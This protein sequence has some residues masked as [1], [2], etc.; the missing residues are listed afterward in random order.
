MKN[1]LKF[2]M[3]L[4][5]VKDLI[6]H[7]NHMKVFM[8]ILVITLPSLLNAAE[9]CNEDFSVK[10]EYAST[11]SEVWQVYNDFFSV[12]KANDK[13]AA[14]DYF[15]GK[16][17]SRSFLVDQLTRID[18]FKRYGQTSL[19]SIGELEYF[20]GAYRATIVDYEYNQ[21]T[22]Q[23]PEVLY[24]ESLDCKLSM[25]LEFENQDSNLLG[26]V[27]NAFKSNDGKLCS[28]G[29]SSQKFLLFPEADSENSSNGSPI[30]LDINV[31]FDQEEAIKPLLSNYANICSNAGCELNDMLI[32][33]FSSQGRIAVDGAKLIQTINTSLDK[34]I[35]GAIRV[36]G[37]QYL[38]ITY[39]ST[40]GNTRHVILPFV[41]ESIEGDMFRSFEYSFLNSDEFH[42]EQLE[43]DSKGG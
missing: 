13:D 39:M 5:S 43:K 15:S 22:I 11:D 29:S 12:A 23:F 16:D 34:A 4:F 40:T 19:S 27:L 38:S 21:R 24:C 6:V 8:V 25:I 17:G 32:D 1:K 20:W 18:K 26:Q 41:E 2:L 10:M 31:E 14:V 35:I 42:I 28:S 36:E 9:Y 3:D 33:V 37:G 30:I 7:R